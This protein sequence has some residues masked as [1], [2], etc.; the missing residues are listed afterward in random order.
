MSSTTITF[1]K[2]LTRSATNKIDEEQVRRAS[3]AAQSAINSA[4][5]GIFAAI[6]ISIEVNSETA[7]ILN[8]L[9]TFLLRFL[10]EF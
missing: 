3:R 7:L 5:I 1:I 2:M 6:H 4:A 9:H 10:D 8:G